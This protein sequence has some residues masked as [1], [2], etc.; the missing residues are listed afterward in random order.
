[1]KRVGLACVFAI[2]S[3]TQDFEPATGTPLRLQHG[4]LYI[5]VTHL[6]AKEGCVP[7]EPVTLAQ[8][9]ASRVEEV[10]REQEDAGVDVINDGEMSKPCQ[11]TCINDTALRLAAPHYFPGPLES[12]LSSK[13]AAR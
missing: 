9:A 12:G 6:I 13:D 11:A 2:V 8:R 5:P 1:M 4:N 3:D 10:V 7:I